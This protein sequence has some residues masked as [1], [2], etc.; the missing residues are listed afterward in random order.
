M[1]KIWVFLINDNA[2]MHFHIPCPSLNVHYPC[3]LA[4]GTLNISGA[5]GIRK[6]GDV[7]PLGS[8][9]FQI[10]VGIGGGIDLDT[11]CLLYLRLVGGK[12]G[13][14]GGQKGLPSI[15]RLRDHP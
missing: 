9:H 5:G 7:P 3:D 13:Q 2:C 14:E 15:H 12:G 10:E 11:R 8:N 4:G 6:H 1:P